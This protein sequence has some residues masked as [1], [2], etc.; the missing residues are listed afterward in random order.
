MTNTL[1]ESRSNPG[2]NETVKR[3]SKF[4]YALFNAKYVGKDTPG[5]W[6]NE[7]GVCTCKKAI[8]CNSPGKHPIQTGFVNSATTNSDVIEGLW[9]RW[10]DANI[11]IVLNSKQIVFDIDPRNGGDKTLKALEKQH[12]PLP[13]RCALKLQVV[14]SIFISNSLGQMELNSKEY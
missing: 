6:I 14:V 3:H 8:N 2:N 12:D 9:A 1:P 13:K 4:E 7:E 11:G 10:P 5:H